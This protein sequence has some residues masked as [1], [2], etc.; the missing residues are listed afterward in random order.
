MT[1]GSGHGDIY[2]LGRWGQGYF[3][4]LENGDFAL[5]NPL[6][7]EMDPISL[8]EII[9]GLELRGIQTPLLLRVS[10]YLEH[11]IGQINESFRKAIARTG[12][13]G[14]YRGVFPI[15]VNQQ[16]QVVDRIV[17][18]GRPWGYGLEAGSKPEL[19]I[20]LAHDL[21]KE[22]LIVC[23]GVKD[24]EFVGLAIQSRKLGFNTIVVLES[25]REVDTVIETAKA[26]GTEP[27]A[28]GAGE[29]DQ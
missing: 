27:Q 17:E 22:A 19:V 20:A 4:V 18:F 6:A 15:K 3:E 5:R 23:N 21:P 14:E 25:A 2:G 26:L 13:K 7:P 1:Q 29:A 24:A 10:S 9:Q 12:Y 11:A 8:P 28:R 16:A